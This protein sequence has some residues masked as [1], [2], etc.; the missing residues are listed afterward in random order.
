MAARSSATRFR[1]AKLRSGPTF[2]QALE[3][4][5]AGRLLRLEYFQGRP[6][7]E[8]GGLHVSPETVSLLISCGDI[9]PDNDTL[10][11]GTPSQTWRLRKR[12]K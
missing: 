5:R 6:V 8:V 4:M 12:V 9:E 3:R 2:P 11:P 1:A 10:I 7:W